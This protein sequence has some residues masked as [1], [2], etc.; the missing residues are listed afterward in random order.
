MNS[1]Q[2]HAHP[3]SLVMC[4]AISKSLGITLIST[5]VSR[6]TLCPCAARIL[7]GCTESSITNRCCTGSQGHAEEAQETLKMILVMTSTQCNACLQRVC[8]Q[9]A[10][11]VYGQAQVQLFASFSPTLSLDRTM[12]RMS[13]SVGLLRR[14]SISTGR[15]T[16]PLA[17]MLAGGA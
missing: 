5:G 12:L 8:L 16:H 9:T 2:I 7:A 17:S 11:I 1:R 15:L 10:D 14:C 6:T 13:A 3:S 4:T